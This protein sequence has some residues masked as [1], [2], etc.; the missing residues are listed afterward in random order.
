MM[1][2]LRGNGPTPRERPVDSPHSKKKIELFLDRP[3]KLFNEVFARFVVCPWPQCVHQC[4]TWSSHSALNT[5]LMQ[6]SR[7]YSVGAQRNMNCEGWIVLVNKGRVW[8]SVLYILYISLVFIYSFIHL[9]IYYYYY[10]FL[11]HVF[12]VFCS[13][14]L[15]NCVAPLVFR[16]IATQIAWWCVSEIRMLQ[17]MLP[18]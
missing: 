14:W 17:E 18:F 1:T 10:Y 4:S 9:F 15:V 5:D 8:K 16:A 13:I 3:C 11:T 2:L 7:S 12:C 6:A